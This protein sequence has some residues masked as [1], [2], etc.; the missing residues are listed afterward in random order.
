MQALI[1]NIVHCF[2]VVRFVH[3][4]CNLHFFGQCLVGLP[5]NI[6]G[7][8]PNSEL[9]SCG[10]HQDIGVCFGK[11]PLSVYP[12]RA[13]GLRGPH[14]HL[15]IFKWGRCEVI[16]VL[17]HGKIYPQALVDAQ[18]FLAEVHIEGHS[19]ILGMG[20]ESPKKDCSQKKY[21]FGPQRVHHQSFS[22]L[23]FLPRTFLASIFSCTFFSSFSMA[24]SRFWICC[25]ESWLGRGCCFWSLGWSPSLGFF[26]CSFFLSPSPFWFSLGLS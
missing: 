6:D 5:I 14:D 7:G 13:D 22:F 21:K 16:A 12:R 15:E 1:G 19:I 17:V 4:S 2:L 11:A 24:S 26:S 18:F 8:L 23:I 10:R 20:E 9:A 25:F 3:G